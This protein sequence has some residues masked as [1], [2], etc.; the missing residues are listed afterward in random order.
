MRNWYKNNF[1]GKKTP[2]RKIIYYLIPVWLLIVFWL[3]RNSFSDGN[4]PDPVLLSKKLTSNLLDYSLEQ[5]LKLY[6]NGKTEINP[7][8]EVEFSNNGSD[9]FVEVLAE[10][11]KN[12]TIFQKSE[13]F[14]V[15]R[16]DTLKAKFDFDKSFFPNKKRKYH[17]RLRPANKLELTS[18]DI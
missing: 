2:T 3:G 12:D 11:I 1:E 10:V 13:T 6:E 8:I 16:N 9:G 17:V 7:L 5:R 4:K 15:K 14:F 18:N